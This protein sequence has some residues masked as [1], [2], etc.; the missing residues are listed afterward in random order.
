MKYRFN[1][2]K[3]EQMKE[4]QKDAVLRLLR[5][6]PQTTMD[7]INNYILAPQKVIQKLREEGYKILTLPVKGQKYSLYKLIEEP[8]QVRLF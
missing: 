5:L 4:S 6:R 7:I 8:K 1:Q 2:K 3:G